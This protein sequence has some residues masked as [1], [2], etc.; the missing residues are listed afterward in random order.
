[1]SS[2]LTWF[3]VLVIEQSGLPKRRAARFQV[4]SP[5]PPAWLRSAQSLPQVKQKVLASRRESEHLRWPKENAPNKPVPP[6]STCD[7]RLLHDVYLMPVRV[8]GISGGYVGHRPVDPRSRWSLE[9]AAATVGGSGIRPLSQRPASTTSPT[10][11]HHCQQT[12]LLGNRAAEFKEGHVPT[13]KEVLASPDERDRHG[14]HLG[15]DHRPVRTLV[16]T[17]QKG[18]RGRD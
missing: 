5:L 10:S 17:K 1:V 9:H 14:E 13:A 6:S 2:Q 11:P 12:S 8:D 15:A 7:G 16:W 3:L 4:L 18:E